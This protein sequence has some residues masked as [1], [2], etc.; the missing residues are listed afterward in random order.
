MAAA[1]TR[2]ALLMIFGMFLIPLSDSA[3]KLLVGQHNVAPQFVA[4][5]RFAMGALLLLPFLTRGEARVH[6]LLDWRITFRGALIAGGILSILTALQSE[7]LPDVFAAFFIGPA[8]SYVLSIVLLG[9]RV[10]L[11]RSA[12]L[13][14]GFIGVLL[15]VRPGFGMTPGLG[16]AVLAGVFYGAYLVASR[17]LAGAASPRTLLLS[18]L[19]TGTVLLTPFAFLHWP[20]LSMTLAGLIALSAAASMA[21]NYLLV[22]A[23]GMAPATRLAPFVYFQLIAAVALGWLI[24]SDLPDALSWAGI[25]LLVLSGFATL[26]LRR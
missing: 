4:W 3:G 25:A 6:H 11:A 18:Q 22:I 17:W 8:V 14:V 20:E 13:G 1:M 9:E 10:S 26:A 16:F 7:P 21:G 12:L 15:V 5:S 2:A 23:Y 24:F 19:V